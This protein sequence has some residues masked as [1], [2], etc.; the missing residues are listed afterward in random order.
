MTPHRLERMFVY[1]PSRQLTE[2]PGVLGLAYSDVNLVAEDGVKLHG[3]FIPCEGAR[4][5]LMIFHGNAGNMGQRL[6]WIERLHDL[7]LHV[8]IFDYR[9]FGRSE[10]DP[11][12]E[13]LYRD[14]RAAYHWWVGER[15]PKGEKLV[16][17]GESLGGAVAVHLAAGTSPAGLIL[18]STFTSA[19][20]MAKTMFPVGRLFPLA[21]VRY[22]SEKDIAKVVCPKIIIHGIRDEIVPFQMGKTLYEAA[23]PPKSFYAVPEA[24]HNDLVLTAGAEYSRQLKLFLSGLAPAGRL[25]FY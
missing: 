5:T 1:Y 16:L 11:F 12:E 25:G 8:F 10:G 2:D 24:G 13:G 6:G 23:P 3:W 20:D 4:I 15:Q 9:G 14:A 19:K 21:G 18:Q 17:I 7:G 22:N